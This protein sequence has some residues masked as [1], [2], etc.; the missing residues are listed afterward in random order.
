[1]EKLLNHLIGGAVGGFI[2]GVILAGSSISPGILVLLK[3]VTGMNQILMTVIYG[4]VV[5][6]IISIIFMFLG[7][8]IPVKQ[9][10]FRYVIFGLIWWILLSILPSLFLG[11]DN[12]NL[13]IS[14][15]GWV[16]Y[17]LILGY[18]S[19]YLE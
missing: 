18:L 1:M 12:M 6:L 15:I 3:A 4:L 11:I 19:E 9:D 10:L 7:K 16:V 5:G 17:G 13:L 14:L 8:T 2:L